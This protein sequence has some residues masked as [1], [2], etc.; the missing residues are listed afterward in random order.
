MLKIPELP[1]KSDRRAGYSLL[2]VLIVLAIIALIATLVGP[3]LLNQLDRSKVTA[4][5][6]QIRS[7]ETAIETF[8]LDLGRY[9]NASEGLN[10]L[11]AAPAGVEGWMGPY[12]N[13]TRVPVDP[14]DRAY[15]Y[16][17]PSGPNQEP[18]IVSLGADG[19]PGGD[20][21]DADVTPQKK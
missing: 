18:V 16:T 8:R 5:K 12:L 17:P 6:A 9:P 4:A 21:L 10:S 14:W 13:G 11:V 1:D 20:G 15:A 7:L 3:R 2:E 19:Q